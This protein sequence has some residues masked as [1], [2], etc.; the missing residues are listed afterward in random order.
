M[1][2]SL[3]RLL[4]PKIIYVKFILF[5]K[6]YKT[7]YHF[8]ILISLFLYLSLIIKGRWCFLNLICRDYH[9]LLIYL[10]LELLLYGRCDTV[11]LGHGWLLPARDRWHPTTSS[12]IRLIRWLHIEI[13]SCWCKGACCGELHLNLVRSKGPAEASAMVARLE[14]LRSVKS[15]RRELLNDGRDLT[16][17]WR[18]YVRHRIL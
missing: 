4:V 11:L 9:H 3:F 2:K 18:D 17:L 5:F 16:G 6:F 8:L 7:K 1:R 12:R 13:I 15:C 14:A 10:M